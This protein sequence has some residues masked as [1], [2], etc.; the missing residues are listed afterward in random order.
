M[1]SSLYKSPPD[2]NDQQ[3]EADDELQRELQQEKDKRREDWSNTTKWVLGISIALAAIAIAIIGAL[4]FQVH[5]FNGELREIRDR[6]TVIET[7]RRME[8]DR[9]SQPLAD[10][11]P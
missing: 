11:A 1:S 4:A 2:A 10:F 5:S 7:E 8:R 3:A 6:I 9:A